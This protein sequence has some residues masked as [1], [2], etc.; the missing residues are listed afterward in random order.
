ML[1][2][3]AIRQFHLTQYEVNLIGTATNIGSTTGILFSLIND[4]IGPRVCSLAAGIVLFGSYFIM[5]LTVSGAI[6][7]AGNYIAM[8]AFMFLVGN[9]SGGAYIGK[10]EFH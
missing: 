4:F 7:E 8:S 10:F 6:P 3:H 5:S 1:A 2:W 9:S